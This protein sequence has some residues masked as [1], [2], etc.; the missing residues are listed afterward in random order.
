M[1][2]LY[3]EDEIS[4]IELRDRLIINN[5]NLVS[6]FRFLISEG[7]VTYRKSIDGHKVST[8]YTITEKGRK[9]YQKLR[10]SMIE[11]LK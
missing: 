11:V 5:G 4:F 3:Q 6:H 10:E 8:I 7:F 1:N 9:E 2:I